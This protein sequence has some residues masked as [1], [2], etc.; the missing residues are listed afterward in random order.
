[1]YC[2]KCRAPLKVDSSLEDLSPAAFDLL[3]R[4]T[5][6]SLQQL[7]KSI[8]PRT[9]SYPPERKELYDRVIAHHQK[10]HTSSL[11][12][13][14]GSS[15]R[16]APSPREQ[17]TVDNNTNNNH[18]GMS[19]VMLTESQVVPPPPSSSS[20]PATSSNSLKPSSTTTTKQHQ[21]QQS[22]SHQL[23][24]T[25]RLYEI[26]SARSDID[27]PIC[28]ECTDLLLEGLQKRLTS[29]S[30]ERDSFNDFLKQITSDIPS[31]EE[32]LAATTSLLHA[33]EE[34][35]KAYSTLLSLEAEKAHLNTEIAKLELES[36]ELDIQESIFWQE[37]NKFS[38]MLTDF[39]DERDSVLTKYEHDARQ[40]DR[41]QRTNVYNDTFC[42]GH[43]GYFGTINGLRLGRLPGQLVD[44]SEI[45][46]A[47]GQALLLLVT[48][49]EKL[50]YTFKGYKL[51]PMGSMSRIEKW[52]YP[53]L[54][55]SRGG[56]GGQV[57]ESTR[58]T[59]E[60]TTTTG[61]NANDT[62]R[63]KTKGNQNP[64]VT[65]LELYSSGDHLPLGR[66]FLHRKLDNAM[67]AFLE[68]LSQLGDFVKEYSSTSEG[69][70]HPTSPSYGDPREREGVR[71]RGGDARQQGERAGD[72]RERG[73][74]RGGSKI[75]LPYEIKK[76]GK[77]G[78]GL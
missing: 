14:D 48:V 65:I 55:V 20:I 57:N 15:H 40:L 64:K 54:V 36:R 31:S 69:E 6:R 41:L 32:T 59:T 12:K 35:Q 46:A 58:Q 9:A 62:Q 75:Q 26:L 70:V 63:N 18:P 44:W 39:Q 50:G 4:S 66:M 30:K 49:A 43:D 10:Q 73:D 22:I 17:T 24:R 52:E 67:V 76:D 5:S 71:E 23:E 2:Q 68:C 60:S 72:T 28:I 33:R 25:A 45:N 37:R 51:R 29:A 56:G 53:D 3:T 21:Q 61:N 19:F 47:W 74:G 38:L 77:I 27:H 16:P 11:S 8:Q 1:M 78:D 7:S 42:I 13:N 34:E